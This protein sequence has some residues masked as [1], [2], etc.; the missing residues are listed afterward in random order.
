MFY[1]IFAS[2]SPKHITWLRQSIKKLLKINGHVTKSIHDS[3]YQLKYAKAE[4]LKLLPKLYY[5]EHVVCL[6][7]KRA[8]IEKALKISGKHL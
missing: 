2:A 6:P 4:S 5:D 3:T 7:R 8:K 1:T